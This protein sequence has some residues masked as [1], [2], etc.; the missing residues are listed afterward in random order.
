M[1]RPLVNRYPLGLERVQLPALVEQ[2]PLDHR[3]PL[4]RGQRIV[5]ALDGAAG[6]VP[7]GGRAQLVFAILAG[8][9]KLAD[10]RFVAVA[11][12]KSCSESLRRECG[13]QS[14]SRKPDPRDQ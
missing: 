11:G 14:G 13:G 7:L 6:R 12:Q 9:G 3:V 10:D 4:K 2:A 8:E 5:K 1:A